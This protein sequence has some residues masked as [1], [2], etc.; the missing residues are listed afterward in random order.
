[1]R[2]VV[3]NLAVT[4]DGFIEGPRG[5]YDWCLTDMDYGM[6]EFHERIDTIFMGA[7]SYVALVAFGAPYPQYKVIVASRTPNYATFP[8]VT[9]VTDDVAESV[10]KLIREPGKDIWLWGG[11]NLFQ[12]MLQE[13]LV[14]E[15]IL[16]I[17]PL[18]LGG[19]LKLYPELLNRK[20]LKLTNSVTY[21][22]G[23]VQLTYTI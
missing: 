7:K 1:M 23:L 22:T 21:P 5:E 2:K 4:L 3:L 19:G 8:N 18:I 15:M 10:R 17:H 12:Y 13:K 16:S 11:A 6:S 20:N 9:F 14:H